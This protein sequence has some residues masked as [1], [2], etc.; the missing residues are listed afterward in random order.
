MWLQAVPLSLLER[1]AIGENE[2]LYKLAVAICP[3]TQDPS[4][5]LRDDKLSSEQKRIA[6]SV[7]THIDGIY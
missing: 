2:P 7:L 6:E 5:L 3:Q 1:I 4:G